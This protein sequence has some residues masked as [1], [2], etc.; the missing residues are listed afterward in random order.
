MNRRQGMIAA[1]AL[2]ASRWV[3]AQSLP[4][5]PKPVGRVLEVGPD[6]Q[7]RTPSAAAKVAR[8]GDEIRIASAEYA[9]DV[10]VWPQSGL[11]FVGVGKS[12]PLLVA[13]NAAAEGKAI[14]VIQ[15]DNIEI[16]NLVFE[17]C[18]VP[19]RNGAGIRAEGKRL[20]VRHC[21]FRGNET[22]I[23]TS[24]RSDGELLIEHSELDR[25]FTPQQ[26]F[27]HNIYVGRI[28]RF[29]M[30]F[31]YVHGAVVGHNVKTRAAT[32]FIAYNL[33]TDG[34]DGRPS[35][36]VDIPDGGQVHMVG[37]IVHKSPRAEN[38]TAIS[39]GAENLFHARHAFVFAHNTVIFEQDTGNFLLVRPESKVVAPVRLIN[40]VF[41]GQGRLQLP[42]ALESHNNVQV[43]LNGFSIGELANF[44]PDASKAK[45]GSETLT[46]FLAPGETPA[47]QYVHPLQGRAL[48]PNDLRWAGAVQQ[49]K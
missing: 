20:S 16:E 5:A 46:K 48:N 36:C 26:G 22:A 24:N 34:D 6:K 31:C 47:F 44:Q 4:A 29:T 3:F 10:A 12:K 1:V 49:R 15:G 35:Y 37:N 41:A 14:W 45:L 7:L 33:I 30:R 21:I 11:R 2:L 39:Y 43:N 40:N 28:A 23:L 19:D 25:N 9:A 32:N 18:R 17:G 38:N 8:D 42:A 13:Q 27:M